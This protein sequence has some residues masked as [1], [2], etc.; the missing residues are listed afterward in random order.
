MKLEPGMVEKF[1][2]DVSNK[3]NVT[4]SRDYDGVVGLEKTERFAMP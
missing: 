1:V 4:L 3:L 2:T